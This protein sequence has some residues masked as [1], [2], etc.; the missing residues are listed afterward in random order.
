MY[1]NSD[2]T[3]CW[4]ESD[5]D[6]LQPV[7]GLGGA[8]RAEVVFGSHPGLQRLQLCGRSVCGHVTHEVALELVGQEVEVDG[9]WVV[10]GHVP[11]THTHSTYTVGRVSCMFIYWMA[12]KTIN[13]SEERFSA[14]SPL[15]GSR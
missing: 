12:D 5:L 8:G 10:D 6:V 2:C 13:Q 4:C 3:E 11:D 1:S 15:I 7:G 14:S 9:H